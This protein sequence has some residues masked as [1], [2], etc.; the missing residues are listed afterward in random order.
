MNR[1]DLTARLAIEAGLSRRAAAQAVEVILRAITSTVAKGER[2]TL[3]G[4]GTFELRDRAARTGRNPRTG[5]TVKVE[6]TRVPMFRAGNDFKEL[7]NPARRTTPARRRTTAA[8]RRVTSARTR[9]DA[10]R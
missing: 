3:P 10:R 9:R 1:S 6:A 4:F 7:V 8:R 2:V 5:E